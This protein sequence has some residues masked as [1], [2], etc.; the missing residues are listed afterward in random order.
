MLQIRSYEARDLPQIRELI[1]QNLLEVNSKVYPPNVIT[2][3]VERYSE[4]VEKNEFQNFSQFLIVE[5]ES[6]HILG[7]AGWKP[8]ENNS[9]HAYLS[10][11]FIKVENQGEGLGSLLLNAIISDAKRANCPKIICAASLNAIKFYEHLG[12]KGIALRNAGLY[13]NVMDMERDLS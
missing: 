2:F 1:S 9:H 5:D 6:H 11:M 3:L 4:V 10:S 12:F 7:C 8:A 13:G